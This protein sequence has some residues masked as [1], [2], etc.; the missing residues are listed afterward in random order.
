MSKHSA[1]LGVGGEAAVEGEFAV[2]F[3]GLK[4]GLDTLRVF[5]FFSTRTVE[6]F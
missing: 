4:C 6:A 1:L 3:K 2:S 5:H